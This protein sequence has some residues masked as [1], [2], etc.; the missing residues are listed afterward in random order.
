MKAKNYIIITIFIVLFSSCKK[1]TKNFQKQGVWEE[2]LKA[3]EEDNI[4]YLL[5][6]SSDT[7]QCIECNNGRDW[8]KKEKFFRNNLD[9][10]KLVKNRKYS[11]FIESINSLESE[12]N[13]II[14]ITYK[15]KYKGNN[16]IVIYT[17]LKGEEKI[18]FLGAS[19]VP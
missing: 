14:K 7:L 16:Y 15:N 3:A 17:I 2:I 18:K 4:D 12:F 5:E 6:I 11:Y 10:I 8:V 1:S 9:N 19:S 13:E